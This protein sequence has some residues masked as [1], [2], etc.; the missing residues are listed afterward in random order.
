VFQKLANTWQ[1]GENDYKM[2]ENSEPNVGA[3]LR[4]MRDRQG[5]SLRALAERS[6]LS[7]NAISQ[8]ERGENSP[9]VSTLHRLANALGVQITDFFQEEAKQK[10]VLVKRDQ[11]LRSQSNGVL[12]ESLGT[13]LFNQ[14][15]EPFRMLIQPGSGQINDLISHS[16]Q[17]FVHCLEGEIEYMLEDRVIQLERGDSLLFDA[18]QSHGYRNL[19]DQRAALLIV[20]LAFQD[21][22]LTRQLHSQV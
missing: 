6:G 22:Q 7:I 19:T 1:K 10:M 13:G 4:S 17:E 21:L 5:Y 18:T 2:V 15:L 8:I 16:G 11:G 3:R 14:Q 12:M 9:T 20:F